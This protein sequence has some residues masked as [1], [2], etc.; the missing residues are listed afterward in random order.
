[1]RTRH[2]GHLSGHLHFVYIIDYP[3]FRRLLSRGHQDSKNYT[4]WIFLLKVWL[5][6]PPPPHP[7]PK[8]ARQAS[9]GNSKKNIAIFYLP[10]ISW[11]ELCLHHSRYVVQMSGATQVVH[12]FADVSHGSH[13]ASLSVRSQSLSIP[14]ET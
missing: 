5:T 14:N 9:N 2:M 13:S 10:A 6:R 1:M 11:G 12:T 4:G 7:C 8:R 3:L